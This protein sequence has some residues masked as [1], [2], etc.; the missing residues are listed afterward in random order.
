MQLNGLLRAGGG[1][2]ILKGKLVLNGEGLIF[3]ILVIFDVR[4]A[5]REVLG[6]FQATT[7]RRLVVV[8]ALLGLAEQ[9]VGH[10]DILTVFAHNDFLTGNGIG[11]VTKRVDYFF[12]AVCNEAGHAFRQFAY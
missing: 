10:F 12:H 3:A 7:W 8:E 5:M 1:G 11:Y 4:L 2:D 6:T 9:L